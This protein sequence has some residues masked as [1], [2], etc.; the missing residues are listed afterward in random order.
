MDRLAFFGL[1]TA[2]AR[3]AAEFFQSAFGC[4]HV[5]TTRLNGA[6]VKRDFGVTSGADQITLG[7]GGEVIQ[8]TQF[9]TPGAPYP[10]EASSSDL[11]FQHF[12]IVVADMQRAYHHLSAIP[13]WTAI[14]TNGPERLPAATGGVTS[15]KFRDPEGHPLELL[16]FPQGAHPHW[17]NFP[18]HSSCLGIDHSAI[19]VSDNDASIAFYEALGLSVADHS[20]NSGPEQQRLD[21]VLGA[22]V[23]VTALAPRRPTPHLELLCYHNAPIGPASTGRLNDIASTHLVFQASGIPDLPASQSGV[24]RLNDPDG[25]TILIN[26]LPAGS[27]H[28]PDSAHDRMSR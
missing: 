15:F 16:A 12:A 14:S 7:L 17:S 9:D 22:Q 6:D 26:G 2:D 11:A 25:H 4:R 3:S 5:G 21:D 18:P 24:R 19:C 23:D 20:V 13:G 27:A 28:W 8:L 10:R 1:T